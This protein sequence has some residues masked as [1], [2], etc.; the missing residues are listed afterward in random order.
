MPKY[1]GFTLIETLLA[2]VI[3]GILALIGYPR[4]NTAVTLSNVR[5]GRT[6]IV[7]LIARARTVATQTN[8]TAQLEF[9]GNAVLV[10]AR[11]RLSPLVGSIQD[12]VGGIQDLNARY[13]VAVTPPPAPLKFDPRGLGS[14][15]NS[16]GTTILVSRDGKSASITIDALGR[17]R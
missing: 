4:F 6:T 9:D 1:N 14:G 15:F 3:V 2:I 11:P 13:G 5:S 12:T 10:T 16:G 17:V 7:N 8:R